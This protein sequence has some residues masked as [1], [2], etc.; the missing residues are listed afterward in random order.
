MHHCSI[1]CPA[2]DNS[3]QAVCNLTR[4]EKTQCGRKSTTPIANQACLFPLLRISQVIW[5]E[6]LEGQTRAWVAA[7]YSHDSHRNIF[8]KSHHSKSVSSLDPLRGNIFPSNLLASNGAAACYVL[9]NLTNVSLWDQCV[10]H[11]KS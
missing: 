3:N 6:L 8:D 4:D 10:L 7:K 1:C 2:V 9:N 11:F 5:K